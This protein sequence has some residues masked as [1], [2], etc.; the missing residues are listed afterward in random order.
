LGWFHFFIRKFYLI[1][2]L[3]WN[4]MTLISSFSPNIIPFRIFLTSSIL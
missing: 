2:C 1:D 4:F 3:S